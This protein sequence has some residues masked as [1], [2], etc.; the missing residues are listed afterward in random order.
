MLS[1][2]SDA[3]RVLIVEDNEADY[4]YAQELLSGVEDSHYHVQWIS[5][6]RDALEQVCR[7][8]SDVI[9]LDQ[10]LGP[11]S[12]TELLRLMRRAEVVTPVI[13]LTGAH[14]AT[15]DREAKKSGASDYLVTGRINRPG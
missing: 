15:L 10:Y 5:N 1:D 4:A 12:G 9:L 11:D 2:N 7:L 3:V 8:E 14:S 6:H 13:M